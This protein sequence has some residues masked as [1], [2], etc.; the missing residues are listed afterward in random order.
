VPGCPADVRVAPYGLD[1]PVG[2]FADP[3]IRVSRRNGELADAIQ[4]FFVLDLL[5]FEIKI[6]KSTLGSDT[7]KSRF[8]IVGI[9][10]MSRLSCSLRRQRFVFGWFF[11][12]CRHLKISKKGRKQGFFLQKEAKIFI[13]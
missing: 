8:R 6:G 12:F 9:V 3:D 1:V 5:A 4:D 7:T 11:C 13:S 10:Q 2:I